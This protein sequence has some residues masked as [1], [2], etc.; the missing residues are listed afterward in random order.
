MKDAKIGIYISWL[1][2]KPDKFEVVGS[3]P[4]MP[5]ICLNGFKMKVNFYY[6]DEV[7]LVKR[8]S[9]IPNVDDEVEYM[10]HW[11]KVADRLF[12]LGKMI[13]EVD[14]YLKIAVE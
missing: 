12:H 14:I 8:M 3:S 10:G 9:C 2:S 13:S 7:L 1:D 11:F 4:T 5:T 6:G